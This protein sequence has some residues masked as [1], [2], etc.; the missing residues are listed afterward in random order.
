[1]LSCQTQD[2][3]LGHRSSSAGPCLDWHME[4]AL[5]LQ[6]TAV[7]SVGH[8]PP[9]GSLELVRPSRNVST[10]SSEVTVSQA[11]I[12]SVLGLMEAMPLCSLG[13]PEV[14]GDDKETFLECVRSLISPRLALS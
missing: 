2:K 9:T 10:F 5:L 3:V 11:T 4:T 13:W 7:L 1:M 14:M 8:S 6:P 12:V